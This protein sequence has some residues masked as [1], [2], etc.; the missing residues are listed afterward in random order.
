MSNSAVSV[1]NGGFCDYTKQEYYR[2]F[3]C[4]FLDV[5]VDQSSHQSHQLVRHNNVCKEIEVRSDM[6]VPGSL[7]HV[8][9]SVVRI[10]A[11]NCYVN[12]TDY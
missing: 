9:R 1:V 5:V 4:S 3:Y 8:L 2:L 10:N 6:D 7:I 11:W 12:Y